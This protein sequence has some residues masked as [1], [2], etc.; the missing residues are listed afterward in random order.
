MK[1]SDVVWK[2]LVEEASAGSRKEPILTSFL[3][4]TILNHKCMEDALSFH[5]A[6]KLK[7]SVLPCMLVR[8]VIQEAYSADPEL[9]E[10]TS[11]DLKAV[12]ERDPASRGFI[13]PF[14]YFKG[15]QAL[16]LF[17]VSH[18]LWRESRED[19]ALFIQ[20]R[21]S[22]IF[23]VD[24]HPAADI[25]CGILM[26][27]ATG[28]VIGETAVVEENVSLLHGVTLGGT[29]KQTGDRHPKV[30]TGVLIGAGAKILGNIEIG[31]GAKV[32]A[33][34]V[35]LDSVPPHTT[36]AGIPAKI[37]GK[38]LVVEPAFSM[39]HCISGKAWQ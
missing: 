12:K 33:G 25:G 13:T 7:D 38:P 2:T 27:H 8:E 16:Q 29:G 4:E 26:D 22:E 24:I 35:V 11:C 19:F 9:I 17:R 14:L 36:V 28:V 5:L 34:S 31:Q 6:N 21:L 1:Y 20:S 32:G 10:H 30:R 18:W 39:D 23:G 37:I 3:F 15:F